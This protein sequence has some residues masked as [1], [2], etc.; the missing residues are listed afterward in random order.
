MKTQ[1]M[2]KIVSAVLTFFVLVGI[3][4]MP[5]LAQPGDL[6]EAAGTVLALAQAGEQ[7][8]LQAFLEELTVE[9]RIEIVAEL[10]GRLGREQVKSSFPLLFKVLVFIQPNEGVSAL[11]AAVEASEGSPEVVRSAMRGLIDGALSHPTLENEEQRQ[12]AAARVVEAAAA[13]AVRVAEENDRID[14]VNIAFAI[15]QGVIQAIPPGELA[16]ARLQVVA[17]AMA[18]GGVGAARRPNQPAVARAMMLALAAI[19]DVDMRRAAVAGVMAG[20]EA[21][22]GLAAADRMIPL[23]DTL[24]QVLPI[25]AAPVAPDLP[26]IPTVIPEEVSPY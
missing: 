24:N 4:S 22:G 11:A 14:V 3:Y 7:E 19:E 13:A 8:D 23:R 20:G 6:S 25:L 5:A 9:R 21:A 18:R 2:S 10:A 1:P 16:R 12:A 26:I 15:A 17:E